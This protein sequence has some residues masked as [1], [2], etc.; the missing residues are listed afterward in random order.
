MLGVRLIDRDDGVC[1][2][3]GFGHRAQADD[4]SGRLFRARD[5][6]FEQLAAL[7]VEGGDEV[8]AVIHRDLRLVS[9]GGV[10]VLVVGGVVFAA[11][12]V[13]GDAVHS[14]ERSGCI[15]LSGERIAG[16]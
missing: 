11:D 9:E 6:V 12:G 7:F 5:D 14:D 8:R 10:D 13:Y 1:E 16:A 2:S 3:A 15:V 4:A